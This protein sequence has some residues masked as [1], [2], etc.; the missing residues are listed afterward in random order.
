MQAAIR[1]IGFILLTV[2]I[3]GCGK[4]SPSGGGTGGNQTPSLIVSASTFNVAYT[5]ST[6]LVTVTSNVNWTVT[7][8]QSW[9]I[10]STS[11]GTNN[12]SFNI[13]VAENP[14]PSLRS[15]TVTITNGILTRTVTIS[16]AANPN[17]NGIT[18]IG[19]TSQNAIFYES[20]NRTGKLLL[21]GSHDGFSRGLEIE[22]D[23]FGLVRA[24]LVNA[25]NGSFT[26][27]AT[28]T[29]FGFTDYNLYFN[30]VH[31][32]TGNMNLYNNPD[33]AGKLQIWI[34]REDGQNLVAAVNGKPAVK[35][36]IQVMGR[37]ANSAPGGDIRLYS[38]DHADYPV[39]RAP[40]T[41][42]SQV[43]DI[44]SKS[45]WTFRLNQFTWPY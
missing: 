29:S 31:N 12:G 44:F 5:S 4:D 36:I 41:N 2:N 42:V 30:N 7:D 40:I 24:K 22:N 13:S 3:L 1:T 34:Y 37:W 27:T 14:A 18:L 35:R 9:I 16:Q 15:G 25:S 43:E 21:Y 26:A 45:K 6:N 28:V 32:Y 17:F 23:S 10:C 39:H 19:G 20:Y 8:D 33:T 11:S 38:Y